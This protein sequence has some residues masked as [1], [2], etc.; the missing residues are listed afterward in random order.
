MF[1]YLIFVFQRFWSLKDFE[2]STSESTII[3]LY[4]LNNVVIW[5]SLLQVKLKRRTVH[6]P[7]IWSKHKIVILRAKANFLSGHCLRR[8][9][10]E[11]PGKGYERA[12]TE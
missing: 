11:G 5:P 6:K 1:L 2:N 10:L 12:G 9:S 8:Q 3:S 7:S 4:V